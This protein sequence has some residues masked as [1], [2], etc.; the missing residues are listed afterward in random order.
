MNCPSLRPKYVLADTPTH[1]HHPRR[2][3]HVPLSLPITPSM[4]PHNPVP[5]SRPT[6]PIPGRPYLFISQFHHPFDD[7]QPAPSKHA[8]SLHFICHCKC[9]V[10]YI[11]YLPSSTL[12]VVPAWRNHPSHFVSHAV[13]LAATSGGLYHICVFSHAQL[14]G[15]PL[16]D[17]CSRAITSL[18]RCVRYPASNPGTS[19]TLASRA[20]HP[21]AMIV[22]RKQYGV[23]SQLYCIQA[24]LKSR[25]SRSRL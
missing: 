13:I 24:A 25:R 22:C 10:S 11:P 7:V 1:A 2:P 18:R 12:Q 14:P 16:S 19:A 3:I 15:L 17:R 8:R 20:A 9:R 4:P 6:F 21:F 23:P 5:Y